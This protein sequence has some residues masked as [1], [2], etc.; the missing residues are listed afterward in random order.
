[1][2]E[3]LVLGSGCCGF[4]RIYD[5]FKSHFPIRYKGDR[6]KYQNL[7]TCWNPSTD[8]IWD[9]ESQTPDERRRR[10]ASQNL[11][12]D[13]SHIYL[14]YVDEIL[15]IRPNMKFLCLKGERQNSI[16]SLL[17]SW[18]YRNP[19]FVP[20]RGLGIGRNRYPVDQFP[21]LSHLENELV[22][23]EHYWD[24]YYQLAE[25][26][27]DKFPNN[28]LVVDSP[29]FFSDESYQKISLNKLGFNLPFYHSPVD[30]ESFRISTT[31]HGGLGNNLFQ[32]SE[33]IGFCE[34]YGL[35][36][37][38][39]GTWDLWS[40]PRFPRYYNSDRFLGGHFGSQ[41]DMID[42]FSNLNWREGLVADYDIK[43]AINDMFRFG[44]IPNVN[45][46][47]HDL[48]V[49][50]IEGENRCSLHLRFCT[51]AAD[52]HVNGLVS[53]DFYRQVF[54]EIPADVK[55]LV[56][57]DDLGEATRKLEWFRSSFPHSFELV[58]LDSFRTLELM[59]NCKYNVMH[60]STFSF[61]GAFL[62]SHVI[63]KKVFCPQSFTHPHGPEM[64]PKTLG[65]K[66]W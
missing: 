58:D 25:Q 8:L 18:G 14:R 33:V 19:C 16:K 47:H 21:N 7:F 1:M 38:F 56:F 6:C 46:I 9:I 40:N 50:R 31:L 17:I 29:Q 37:P 52:D 51:R 34:K 5:M 2:S 23:I 61:W 48:G 62:L 44:Q 59:A 57:A 63:D 64:I 27:A 24:L 45:Q 39:F 55:V 42:T 3:I 12:A 11:S 32:M 60:V 43:F 28:F 54:A 13:I 49:R 4:L 36:K 66:I 20:E 26:K 30:L 15:E 41:R 53:D 35:E 10:V 65:W 22:A